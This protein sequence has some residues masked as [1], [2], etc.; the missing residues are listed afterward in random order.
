MTYEKAKETR[1]DVSVATKPVLYM[2]CGSAA[3]DRRV[4]THN[5]AVV[6]ILSRHRARY[7]PAVGPMAY[8][9]M[10]SCECGGCVMTKHLCG[11]RAA[12]CGTRRSAQ[13]HI[14]HVMDNILKTSMLAWSA[15]Y[16]IDKI[17]RRTA[18]PKAVTAITG[19]LAHPLSS[20]FKQE[21]GLSDGW[22]HCS[23]EGT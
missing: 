1:C 19:A 7:H 23:C 18:T 5:A 9:L 8:M 13:Q 17:E 10:F 2:V 20:L 14:S 16:D 15:R 6:T 3:V 22:K 12:A 11:T 21:T 4:L